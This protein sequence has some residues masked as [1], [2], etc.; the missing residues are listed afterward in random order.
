MP[1]PA[2]IASSGI[3]DN[4]ERLLQKSVAANPKALSQTHW[5]D[6]PQWIKTVLGDDC[7]IAFQQTRVENEFADSFWHLTGVDGAGSD[8]VVRVKAETRIGEDGNLDYE[9]SSR[10]A[11]DDLTFTLT[12]LQLH[13]GPNHEDIEALWA[14]ASFQDHAHY[15]I[16]HAAHIPEGRILVACGNFFIDISG[17]S[18]SATLEP[19]ARKILA[20][21]TVDMPISLHIP[22]ITQYS[23]ETT[24]KSTGPSNEIKGISSTFDV[25]CQADSVITAASA[26]V[27]GDGLVLNGYKIE[28]G[29][30]DKIS[31]VTF[32]FETKMVGTHEINLR[33]GGVTMN[34]SAK[35]VQVT[36]V[37]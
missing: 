6:V 32:T 24:D 5:N 4:M 10:A 7:D 36:V 22:N 8:V 16:Q 27:E 26:S 1:Y 20:H 34:T 12:N 30:A 21:T 29:D 13:L 31:T 3:S 19:I 35:K 14:P 9:R 37:D 18:S 33:L 23:F 28:V 25:K 17:G 2:F 15:A 11:L